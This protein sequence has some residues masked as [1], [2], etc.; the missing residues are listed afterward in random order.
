MARQLNQP[1]LPLLALVLL[2]H[3]LHQPLVLEASVLLPTPEE[4]SL[5]TPKPNRDSALVVPLQLLPVGLAVLA[6]PLIQLGVVCLVVVPSLEV[7]LEELRLDLELELGLELPQA[8]EQVL[9][10]V[11]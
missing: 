11:H 2:L 4:V 1:N 6:Q 7:S 8:L 10:Q 9:P 5:A 3:Q